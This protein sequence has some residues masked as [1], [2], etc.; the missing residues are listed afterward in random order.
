MRKI[1]DKMIVDW[2]EN[3]MENILMSRDYGAP[4]NYMASG[5]PKP[6][7]TFQRLIRKGAANQN[8]WSEREY[9][10]LRELVGDALQ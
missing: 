8:I 9:S 2:L 10:S 7:M 1:T 6:K 5:I 4:M 3:N